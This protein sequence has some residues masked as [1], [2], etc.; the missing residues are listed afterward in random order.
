MH[1]KLYRID[2]DVISQHIISKLKYSQIFWPDHCKSAGSGSGSFMQTERFWCNVAIYVIN[3][4][5]V[6]LIQFTYLSQLRLTCVRD[7]FN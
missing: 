1:T 2:K 3:L 6:S 4:C 5:V 7:Q